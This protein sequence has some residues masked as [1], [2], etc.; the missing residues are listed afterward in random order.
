VQ[1]GIIDFDPDAITCC[2]ENDGEE[3]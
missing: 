2:I 1:A 3:V